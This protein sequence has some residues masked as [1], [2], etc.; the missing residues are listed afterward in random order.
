MIS[1]TRARNWIE[2]Q[3]G[4][5]L[6]S[7]GKKTIHDIKYFLSLA[8]CFWWFAC[9]SSVCVQAYTFFDY[10]QM[11]WPDG[12][13][14]MD[15]T[16]PSLGSTV[17]YDGSTSWRAVAESALAIWN[18]YVNTIRF[19]VFTQNQGPHR[20]GD[21]INQAFFDSTVY[22]QSFGQSTLALTLRR[23][24]GT[25]C[26]EADTIFNSTLPW[27]SYSGNL[28]PAASGGTL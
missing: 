16:D 6:P 18:Q 27:N 7:F 28:L 23:S 4:H 1:L 19:T 9:G 20:L 24:V 3:V 8:A 17:L 15:L 25:S 10:P 5:G 2:L 12:T 13:I 22:G 11:P 26:V 21:Q 14:P